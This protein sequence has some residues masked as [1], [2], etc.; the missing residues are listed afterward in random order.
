MNPLVQSAMVA[1]KLQSN[2]NFEWKL[3]TDGTFNLF[4]EK[5][6]GTDFSRSF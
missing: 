3:I 4:D 2:L 1:H 5:Y 6:L